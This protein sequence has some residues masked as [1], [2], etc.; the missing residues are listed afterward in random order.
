MVNNESSVLLQN[1]AFTSE[2]PGGQTVSPNSTPTS[3]QTA[4]VA[5]PPSGLAVLDIP[6]LWDT[7]T[8]QVG[9]YAAV[10]A[11]ANSAWSGAVLER[12]LDGVTWSVVTT[13]SQKTLIGKTL[14]SMG[15]AKALDGLELI[16]DTIDFGSTVY[17]DVGAGNSLASVDR[18]MFLNDDTTNLAW[19]GTINPTTGVCSGEVLRFQTAVLISSGVY[20]LTNCHRGLYGTETKMGHSSDEKFVLLSPGGGV[21]FCTMPINRVGVTQYF[22]VTSL[23]NRSNTATVQSLLSSGNNM[24]PY[25]PIDLR[26]VRA[27]SDAVFTW[28]RRTRLST[29]FVGA[30]PIGAPLGEATEQYRVNVYTSDGV[31]LVRST[32]VT[33]PTWTYSGAMQVSDFGSLQ[34]HVFLRV[35]Q[36]SSVTG[37]GAFAQAFI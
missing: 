3:G 10:S 16:G 32:T 13:F 12:S 37:P 4:V 18:D 14:T 1:G 31:V 17:V 6:A 11:P 35:A 23:G 9:F 15:N 28:I 19:I 25:A 20:R 21:Q 30:V 2:T 7:D 33:S 27:S 8:S 22:R 34:S 5:V 24:R 26:V 29:R 36:I